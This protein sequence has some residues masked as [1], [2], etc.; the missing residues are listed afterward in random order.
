MKLTRRLQNQIHIYD[1]KQLVTSTLNVQ[2]I[3][4][5][6]RVQELESRF[7]LANQI[8]K[9]S[10]RNHKIKNRIKV[11]AMRDNMQK[12]DYIRHNEL[13]SIFNRQT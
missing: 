12:R 7:S 9:S 5:Q 1:K 6:R 2:D 4:S 13:E 10:E 8:R 3:I 11:E